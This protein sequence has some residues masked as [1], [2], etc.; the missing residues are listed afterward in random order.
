MPALEERKRKIEE[1]RP[2]VRDDQAADGG[3]HAI[4]RRSSVHGNKHQAA[5]DQHAKHGLCVHIQ[6]VPAGARSAVKVNAGANVQLE[7]RV[8]V[9]T[10]QQASQR[11]DDASLQENESAAWQHCWAR[12]VDSRHRCLKSE[13][14]TPDFG[15]GDR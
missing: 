13:R 9:V 5:N 7:E 14:M 4:Q 6:G 2:V 10:N 12:S 3:P 11:E 1:V 15:R 8:R